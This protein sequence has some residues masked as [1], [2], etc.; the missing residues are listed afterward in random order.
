LALFVG[1]KKFGGAGSLPFG[2]GIM[3]PDKKLSLSQAGNHDFSIH[4]NC[5]FVP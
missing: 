1:P 3:V 5:G 4:K 2:M